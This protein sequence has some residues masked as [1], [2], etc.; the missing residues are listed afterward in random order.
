M[1]IG[2][3][4]ENMSKEKSKIYVGD[5]DLG[6]GTWSGLAK[7]AESVC[8]SGLAVAQQGR[9][10]NE[11]ADRYNLPQSELESFLYAN[12]QDEQ[13]KEYLVNGAIL[14]CTR[15]TK[16]SVP[17]QDQVYQCLIKKDESIENEIDISKY[18][19][20]V[21]Q[22]LV[23]TENPT[24]ESNGL[25]FAT[26]ADA[27]KEN[28]IPF[29]GNCDRPPDN[30]IEIQAFQNHPGRYYKEGTCKLLMNLES[31]WDNYEIGQSFLE[32]PDD[33]HKDKTGITMTSILFCKHGGFIYPIT[34]GQTNNG[35]QYSIEDILDSV[36]AERIGKLHPAI[37]Q[38]AI[39]FICRLQTL[40]PG[41]RISQGLRT[42][43]EQDALYSQ[44]RNG[45]SGSI[46]T[47]AKGGQ[48]YHNYGVAF[49][50][51]NIDGNDINYNFDWQQVS[52]IGKECGFE[53]GG[54]WVS[55]PDRPHFQI[56][57][58]YT[59]AELLE[60]YNKGEVEDGYVIL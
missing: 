6:T 28:N 10:L 44:G 53:W 40:Y 48:S 26:I 56:T 5:S 42:F 41:I 2:K 33:D 7:A 45:N 23:V 36:T 58:G 55:I 35:V 46:V 1:N 19:D 22:R 29:F 21:L 54:D 32:F 31:K 12:Y 38:A 51:V 49:D 16:S 17:Y 50:I 8:Y 60:K 43:A 20:K 13:S 39:N 25:K 59:T 52:D 18:T 57:Y 9:L 11:T 14:T 3:Q 37:R 34:S 47:N 27:M 15:C 30:D 4:I 24:S